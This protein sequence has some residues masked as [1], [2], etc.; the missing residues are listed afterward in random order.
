MAHIYF[1]RDPP[2]LWIRP[3]HSLI[4]TL[5]AT[6]I[7]KTNNYP[8]GYTLRFPRIVQIR[9]DKPWDSVCTVAELKSLI[10]VRKI[11]IRGNVLVC[12]YYFDLFFHFF[13]YF[14][15]GIAFRTKKKLIK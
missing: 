12:N 8:T 5:R 14:F 2:D 11:Y 13:F 6:E 1:Q 15:F 7:V 4:L 3:E 10:K 9:E